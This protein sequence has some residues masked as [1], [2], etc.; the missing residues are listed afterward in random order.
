VRVRR[1]VA[2]IDCGFAVNPS[3][4]EAQVQ[5]AVVYGLAAA[6]TGEITLQGGA[7]EGANFDSH[8]ILRMDE[9][10]RIEVHIVPSREAPGGVGEVATPP[11][12]PAVANAVFAATGRRLRSLPLVRHGVV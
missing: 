3:I 8:P 12:A 11:V 9:M 1:I 7:V 4:V 2:A 6:L 10:P 5:S